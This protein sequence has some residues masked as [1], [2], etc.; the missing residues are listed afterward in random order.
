MFNSGRADNPCPASGDVD[1]GEAHDDPNSLGSLAVKHGYISRDDLESALKLQGER[2]KLGEVLVTMKKLT[3]DQLKELLLEQDVLRGKKDTQ[4]QICLETARK[5]NRIRALG[6][7]FAEAK[8]DAQQMAA[9]ISAIALE[10]KA[11]GG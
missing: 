5:Q 3:P 2:L 8:G 7:T 9:T 1:L 6:D 11:N 4:T 10:L